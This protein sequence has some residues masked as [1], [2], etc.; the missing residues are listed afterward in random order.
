MH[1]RLT[2]LA[3]LF[4]LA[5]SLMAPAPVE[6]IVAQG[7]GNVQNG[8][9]APAEQ[10]KSTAR[11]MHQA[12]PTANDLTPPAGDVRLAPMP[13]RRAVSVPARAHPIAHPARLHVHPGLA[14][15][16]ALRAHRA[17]MRRAAAR[18]A[19]S[20]RAISRWGHRRRTRRVRGLHRYTPRH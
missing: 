18:R 8:G 3:A 14:H 10:P 9:P 5:I 15:L 7:G 4:A 17:A 12:T 13:S 16:R 11:R 6:A 19:V 2:A 20:H 1:A